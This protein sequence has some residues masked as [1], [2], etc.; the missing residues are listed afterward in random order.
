M[1]DLICVGAITGSFGVH[2]EV[3]LKSFTAEPTAL[4]DYSPLVTE[5]G[6]NS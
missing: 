5:D 1:T 2:G 4:A 6:K 3:R